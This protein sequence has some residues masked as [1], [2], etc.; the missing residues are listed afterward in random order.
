MKK[1]NILF[2]SL[3]L[4]VV[5]FTSCDKD[6][7]DKLGSVSDL[8]GT[9]TLE[10]VYGYEKE[11]G[12]ITDEW[13][14]TPD[15]IS[16]VIFKEEGSFYLREEGEE[17]F[18]LGIWSYKNGKLYC[19]YE[20]YEEVVTVK[21]LTPTRLVVNSSTKEDE[22]ES[23][24][25]QIFSKG[26]KSNEKE[27][28]EEEKEIGPASNFEGTWIQENITYSKLQNNKV[29]KQET[30]KTNFEITFNKEGTFYSKDLDYNEFYHGTWSY[31]NGKLTTIEDG[32]KEIFTVEELTSKKLVLSQSFQEGEYVELYVA[33]FRKK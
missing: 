19:E 6:D 33:T 13:D 8:I 2:L 24:I 20:D 16:Q 12:K 18:Y 31:K 32:E 17:A 23:N 28:N 30:E 15:H 14:E 25:T 21:E 11:N 27:E 26:S 9:W 5:G 1:N 4:L 7:D 22:Y 10:R 29:I 3:M